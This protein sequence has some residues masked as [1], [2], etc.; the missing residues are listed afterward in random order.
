MDGEDSYNMQDKPDYNAPQ[1]VANGPASNDTAIFNTTA[2]RAIGS[3]SLMS[4]EV[5]TSSIQHDKKRQSYTS[6]TGK[7]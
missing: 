7:L 4:P 6:Q 5:A 1:F 2:N 3:M